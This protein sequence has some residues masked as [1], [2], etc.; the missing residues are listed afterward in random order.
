MSLVEMDKSLLQ[1]KI[2]LS[3]IV[4]NYYIL[5]YVKDKRIRNAHN[6]IVIGS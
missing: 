2:L 5:T 1:N 4:F 6:P 3:E